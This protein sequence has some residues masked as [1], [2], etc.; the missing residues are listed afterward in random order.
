MSVG[1]VATAILLL[2][3]F[4]FLYI[5]VGYIMN[6]YQE[7]TNEMIETDPY[8]SNDRREAMN[9]AFNTWYA[10]PVAV[11]ILVIVFVVLESIKDRTNEI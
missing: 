3:V 7:K 11:F 5:T 6:E 1:A 4:S 2:A 10:F 8:Y 9:S